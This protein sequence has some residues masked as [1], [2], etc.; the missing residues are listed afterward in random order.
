MNTYRITVVNQLTQEVVEQDLEARCF[1]DAQVLLLTRMFRQCGWRSAVA[2]AAP[3]G[4]EW[5][6]QA[7]WHAAHAQELWAAWQRSQEGLEHSVPA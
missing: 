1:A 6:D 5:A 7:V 3:T 2:L 4:C